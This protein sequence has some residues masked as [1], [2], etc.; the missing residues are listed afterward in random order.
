MVQDSVAT[1][2][3]RLRTQATY[4][5]HLP[6]DTGELPFCD[7]P[8]QDGPTEAINGL[9]ET[10]SRQRARPRHPSTNYIDRSPLA[11]RV[12]T[13]GPPSTVANDELIFINP[14]K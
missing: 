1:G 11:T 7:R 8:V 3:A 9:P 10:S 4:G 14:R 6:A 2:G 5:C 12:P 13:A